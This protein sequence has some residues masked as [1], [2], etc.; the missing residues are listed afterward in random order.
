MTAAEVLKPYKDEDLPAFCDVDLTDVNQVGLFG[1]RPLDIAAVRGSIEEL[2]A[3]LDAGAEVN[4]P[5]ECGN[6]PL[7]EAVSQGHFAVAK[8]L[9]K[10]GATTEMR[11]QFGQTPLDIARMHNRGDLAALLDTSK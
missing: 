6:T 11:N 8:L 2:T 3:L 1:E 7:H 10:F 5:G 9:L 4:A